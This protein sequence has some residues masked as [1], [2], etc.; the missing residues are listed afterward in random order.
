M[1]I[2]FLIKLKNILQSNLFLLFLFIG[3]IL[4]CHFHFYL[5]HKQKNIEKNVI[6]KVKIQNIYREKGQLIIDG[7]AKKRIRIF[8]SY[9]DRKEKYQLGDTIIVEG[10]SVP[11]GRR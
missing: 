4:Y 10:I 6:L 5:F 7:I 8:Y 2:L 1:E 9:H 11:S 3:V